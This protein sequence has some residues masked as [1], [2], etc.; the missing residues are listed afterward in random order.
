MRRRWPELAA[1]A[2]V[3]LV[4][5]AL[6]LALVDAAQHAVTADVVTDLTLLPVAAAL[7][8]LGPAIVRRQPGNRIGRLF[9]VDLLLAGVINVADAYAASV[10]HPSAGRRPH[11]DL[12]V[13]LTGFLW[14]PVVVSV[15]AAV[16]IIFPTGRPA[17][18]R[19]RRAEQLVW[20]Q[21]ALLTVALA[22]TPG[23]ANGYP[24]RN[25]VTPPPHVLFKALAGIGFVLLIPCVGLAAL[26]IVLRYRRAQGLER[27]QLK[28]L[29]FGA[30]IAALSFLLALITGVAGFDQAFNVAIPT[31]LTAVVLA[32]GIAVLRYRLYDVD[33]LISRTLSYGALTV[34]LAAAYAGL[35]LAGQA[36]FS[37]F[38]GGS[39]LAV[40]VSTLIVAALFL[41]LRAGVQ[42][43]VDRRFNRRRY[44]A[45]RTLDDFAV[46]VRKQVD[47]GVLG[48]ELVRVVADTMQPAHMT[49]WLRR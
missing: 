1:A 38:T 44:D 5:V 9:C 13:W 33:R 35:V 12:A 36:L 24:I 31:A 23:S 28:W 14:V 32:A 43:F 40:A 25:P 10:A 7:A 29:A 6:A 16:P 4:L 17:S 30:S 21:V 46:R 39:N 49:L 20:G 18:P 48:G 42:R 47:T 41:P 15:I 27:Q 11:D 19:W 8:V 3:A 45:Q 22:F 34:I 26:A 37:A 2:G